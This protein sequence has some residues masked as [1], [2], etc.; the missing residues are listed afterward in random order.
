MRFRVQWQPGAAPQADAPCQGTR[1]S[2]TPPTP[3]VPELSDVTLEICALLFSSKVPSVFPNVKVTD[4]R[5]RVEIKKT[6]QT[7]SNA[8]GRSCLT[9]VL[10]SKLPPGHDTPH[11]PLT[12]SLFGPELFQEKINRNSFHLCDPWN[13][14]KAEATSH[15][16][17]LTRRDTLD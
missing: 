5:F 15:T 16:P 3:T 10:V 11:M 9:G 7:T 14:E 1:A 13:S 12:L 17:R 8:S 2:S 6:W 4:A